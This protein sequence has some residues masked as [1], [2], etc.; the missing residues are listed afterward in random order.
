[1]TRREDA[2]ATAML[3]EFHWSHLLAAA[4]AAA[5]AAAGPVAAAGAPSPSQ[6]LLTAVN[7]ARAEA[8]VAP[9]QLDPVLSEVARAQ[10][11]EIAARPR[12]ERLSESASFDRLLA[13]RGIA[14]YRRTWKRVDLSKNAE[15]PAAQAALDRW[16][17]SPSAWR[18][19]LDGDLTRLGFGVAESRDGWAVLVIALAQPLE[20]APE[21]L[22]RWEKRIAREVNRVR[23][24]HGLLPL[25]WRDDLAS[26]AR[27]HSRAMAEDGFMGHVDTAGRRPADRVRAAGIDF[28]RIGENVATNKGTED[29]PRTAVEGWMTSPG[30]R[31][32]ILDPDFVET[33]VGIAVGDDG[34]YAFTQ[35]FA[36]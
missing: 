26:V 20:R 30:H 35:L 6:R 22:S 19:A 24:D 16:R 36:E 5:L 32:Q 4:A 34:T 13:E 17:A 9:A 10:A 11:E 28:R 25:L 21:A 29:P 8:G 14:D 1:M 18:A 27:E 31:R 12:S 15:G 3:R 2:A 7:E 23:H 33:G